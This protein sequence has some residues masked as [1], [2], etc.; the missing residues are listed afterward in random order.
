MNMAKFFT[1]LGDSGET[2][3]GKVE[4]GK[5]SELMYAIGD[6]D[7]LNSSIGLALMHIKDK[8]VRETLDA[9]QNHLFII[10]AQIISYVNSTFKPKRG[11]TKEDVKFIEDK[12]EAFSKKVPELK[13]FVLPRGVEG[14]E[15]LHSSR[16]ITRRAERSVVQAKSKG[17]NID[18]EIIRYLNRLS[19]LLFVLALYINNRAGFEEKNPSY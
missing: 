1:G 7:E 14:A 17:F 3:I 5:N 11:I 9:V 18:G 10:G 19:S 16:A 4:F 13:G 6:V 12:I 15:F 8:E 2:F